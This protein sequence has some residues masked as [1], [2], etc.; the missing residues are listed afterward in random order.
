MKAP[1]GQLP[2][3]LDAE[4]HGCRRAQIA[5]AQGLEKERSAEVVSLVD[6]LTMKSVQA[7]R[8]KNSEVASRASHLADSWLK[9]D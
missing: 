4:P 9:K 5:Q 7:A 2:L 1:D 3:L 6:R 8:V